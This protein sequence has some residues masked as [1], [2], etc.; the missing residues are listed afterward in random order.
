M[1]ALLP[2]PTRLG[3][4]DTCFYSSGKEKEVMSEVE[5]MLQH[6]PAFQSGDASGR[7]YVLSSADEQMIALHLEYDDSHADSIDAQIVRG[8]LM[9]WLEERKRVIELHSWTLVGRSELQ[10]LTRNRTE[11]GMLS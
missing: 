2:S 1:E 8:K 9:E 7:V 5:A 3:R 4:E 6:S 11:I 10:V